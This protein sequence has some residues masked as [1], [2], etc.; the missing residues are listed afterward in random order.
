MLLDGRRAFAYAAPTT[1]NRITPVRGCGFILKRI[2]DLTENPNMPRGTYCK[3]PTKQDIYCGTSWANRPGFASVLWTAL[4]EDGLIESEDGMA[5]YDGN[6]SCFQRRGKKYARANGHYEFGHGWTVRYRLTD[7]GR[8]IY[9]EMMDRISK[10]DIG[11][12][13]EEWREDD[14]LEPGETKE[15]WAARNGVTLTEVPPGPAERE[16]NTKQ[17]LDAIIN[18]LMDLRDS[19]S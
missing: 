1:Y 13:P 19:L 15:E 14:F 10:K 5:E 7:K 3:N 8:R 9:N 2:Y 4:L 12:R 11:P 17:K 16:F 18:D 6:Y